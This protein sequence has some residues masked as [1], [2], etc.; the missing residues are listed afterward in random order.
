MATFAACGKAEET[1]GLAGVH[2]P[3]AGPEPARRCPAI[4]SRGD[5]TA[6]MWAGASALQ[7][8]LSP[9]CCLGL[10]SA[11]VAAYRLPA[12]PPWQQCWQ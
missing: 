2:P 11:T 1:T 12:L 8:D 5:V 6:S 4:T 10:D 7:N 9:R 3:P